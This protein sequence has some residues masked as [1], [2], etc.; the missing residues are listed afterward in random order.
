MAQM[1][2]VNPDR[3]AVVGFFSRG[4]VISGRTFTLVG[5]AMCLVYRELDY[6]IK[7]HLYI[8]IIIKETIESA[9]L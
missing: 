1:V 6:E 9:G 8:S 4:D 7:H 5:E 2:N 3:Q